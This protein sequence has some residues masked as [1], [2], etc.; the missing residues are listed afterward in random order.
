MDC[1]TPRGFVEVIEIDLGVVFDY[2]DE[3]FDVSD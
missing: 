1:P 3:E 2:G